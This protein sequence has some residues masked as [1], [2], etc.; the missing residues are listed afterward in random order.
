[1]ISVINLNF[2]SYVC[3]EN[4]IRHGIK[5]ASKSA[6]GKHFTFTNAI[7]I[8]QTKIRYKL[9]FYDGADDPKTN[10]QLVSRK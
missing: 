1:M 4:K 3:S 6:R 7:I 2:V 8:C 9:R 5:N 10:H